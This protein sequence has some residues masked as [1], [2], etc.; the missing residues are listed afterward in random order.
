MHLR[1]SWGQAS[2]L[3]AEPMEGAPRSLGLISAQAASVV[4]KGQL[5]AGT[6]ALAMSL[7]PTGAPTGPILFVGKLPD[8]ATSPVPQGGHG[9]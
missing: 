8:N 2:K 7:E 9:W 1:G 6:Q 4:K 3:W 5:P